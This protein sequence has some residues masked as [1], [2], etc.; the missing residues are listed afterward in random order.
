MTRKEMLNSK[1][2]CYRLL[3]DGSVNVS[4]LETEPVGW[5]AKDV[6][7]STRWYSRYKNMDGHL[8]TEVWDI[9]NIW[10]KPVWRG[11]DWIVNQR[12]YFTKIW[13]GEVPTEEWFEVPNTSDTKASFKEAHKFF[14][15]L[16]CR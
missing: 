6:T 10:I 1:K 16:L 9:T 2:W 7:K 3:K 14:M 13:E 4:R 11:K 15:N 5:W 12:C 8:C